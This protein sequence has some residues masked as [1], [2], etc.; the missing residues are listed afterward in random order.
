MGLDDV[1]VNTVPEPVMTTLSPAMLW[2]GLETATLSGLRLDLRVDVYLD[3]VAMGEGPLTMPAGSSGFDDAVLRTVSL[4]LYNGPW[5]CRKEAELHCRVGDPAN[6][7]GGGRNWGRCA[8]GSGGHRRG[9]A[10]GLG[11]RLHAT[12]N[13]ETVAYFL[14]SGSP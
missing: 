6:M 7:L 12:I 14:D 1:V 2:V 5:A 10:G 13:D 8:C 11:G 9:K 4:A 3:D